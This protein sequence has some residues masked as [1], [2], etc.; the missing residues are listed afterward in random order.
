MRKRKVKKYEEFIV[1]MGDFLSSACTEKTIYVGTKL[2]GNDFLCKS[3]KLVSGGFWNDITSKKIEQKGYTNTESQTTTWRIK[4][5]DD[6]AHITR[7]S[8]ASQTIED[9]QVFQLEKTPIKDGLLLVSLRNAGVSPEVITIDPENGS[10]VYST[11]H[12]NPF[13][14]RTNV[15]YGECYPYQ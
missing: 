11:Q 2:T 10:F 5:K 14:N 13:Y 12:V 4:I 8:G 7:Y 1:D 6:L 15:F 9:P 3:N